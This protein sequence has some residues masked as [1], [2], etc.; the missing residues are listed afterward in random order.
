MAFEPDQQFRFPN[1]CIA[2]GGISLA[3]ELL[4]AISKLLFRIFAVRPDNGFA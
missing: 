4:A 1:A 2:F 3:A